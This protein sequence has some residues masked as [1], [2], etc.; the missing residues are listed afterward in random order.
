MEQIFVGI[1][2]GLETITA[3]VVDAES[4]CLLEA[5]DYPNTIEGYNRLISNLSGYQPKALLFCVENTGVYSESLCYVLEEGGYRVALVDPLHVSRS[6]RDPGHKTDK[7]DSRKIAEYGARFQDKLKLWRPN[8]TSVE[9]IRVL[10]RTRE[11]LVK[12]K[13]SSKNLLT[14]LRRKYIQTP[15]ANHAL[16]ETITNLKTQIKQIEQEISRLISQHPTLAQGAT[17]VLSLKGAGLLLAAHMA[18]LTKGFTVMLNYRSTAAYLGVAPRAYQSGKTIYRRP[19]SRQ[20]GPAMLRKLLHLSA[21]SLIASSPPHKNYFLRKRA[22][23]KPKQLI[24][25]NLA[26][27]QLRVLCGMLGNGIPYS[28]NYP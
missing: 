18:V 5:K 3:T 2:A 17:L 11:Q 24:L 10:L 16:E 26:N 9:Q 7:L 25:N 21:R 8:Q 23:G 15:S 20:H 1:D 28:E 13:T 4:S 6:V 12:Q 27:K 14:S 22:E 19:R